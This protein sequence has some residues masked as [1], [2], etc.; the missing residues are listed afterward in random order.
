MLAV[1]KKERIKGEWGAGRADKEEKTW[2][3]RSITRRE[4]GVRNRGQIWVSFGSDRT[5]E[6]FW[7][8]DFFPLHWVPVMAA[9]L[10]LVS[11]HGVGQRCSLWSASRS[12]GDGI[13]ASEWD[14]VQQHSSPLGHCWLQWLPLYAGVPK[15]LICESSCALSFSFCP[16]VHLMVC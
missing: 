7:D 4:K 16:H 8:S 6:N 2:D 14:A 12:G 15:I 13:R 11:R 10:D 5:A 3:D 1:K 9:V